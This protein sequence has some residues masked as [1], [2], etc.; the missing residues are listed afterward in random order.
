MLVIF[1]INHSFL[2]VIHSLVAVLFFYVIILCCCSD[3]TFSCDVEV[4]SCVLQWLLCNQLSAAEDESYKELRRGR[5]EKI[6]V[7]F[8]GSDC[9]PEG[10]TLKG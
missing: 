4:A 8:Q 10:C 3:E 7:F 2:G 1:F 6:W 9:Q 5:E